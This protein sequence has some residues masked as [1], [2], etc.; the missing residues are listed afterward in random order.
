MQ[1]VCFEQPASE[2]LFLLKKILIRFEDIMTVQHWHIFGTGRSEIS[3]TD[4][5]I[6]KGKFLR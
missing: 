6:L 4:N 1:D 3:F 5:I 2:I